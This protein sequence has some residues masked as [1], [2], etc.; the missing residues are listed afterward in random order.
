MITA[1][2]STGRLRNKGVAD[3]D[4][5]WGNTAASARAS[6]GAWGREVGSSSDSAC[7]RAVGHGDGGA[8]KSMEQFAKEFVAKLRE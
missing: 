3:C 1:L 2:P 4:S 5:P 6:A 7:V 8:E